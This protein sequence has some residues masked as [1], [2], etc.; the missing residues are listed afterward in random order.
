ML[1][2]AE[3]EATVR[4]DIRARCRIARGVIGASRA[5]GR[6]VEDAELGKIRRTDHVR[7]IHHDP[8]PL[9]RVR[10]RHEAQRGTEVHPCTSFRRA[11]YSVNLDLLIRRL[12]RTIPSSRTVA[13]RRR[14]ADTP[15]RKDDDVVA[16]EERSAESADVLEGSLPLKLSCG[17]P[18]GAS[19]IE[20][21]ATEALCGAEIALS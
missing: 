14:I 10:R 21:G 18:S 1:D 8:H 6:C 7:R 11:D 3:G 20:T 2:A 4:V 15:R 5:D 12:A 17:R 16:D 19:M 13:A 9:R